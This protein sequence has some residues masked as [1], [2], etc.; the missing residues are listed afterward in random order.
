MKTPEEVEAQLTLEIEAALKAGWKLRNGSFGSSALKNC[1]ALTAKFAV[2]DPLDQHAMNTMP[3]TNRL[4]EF[5]I[6]DSA[7]LWSLVDGFDDHWNRLAE[8]RAWFAVGV[9][10]RKKFEAV[11]SR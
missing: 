1:C 8:D 5:G 10:L 2:L 6:E 4:E 11:L 9:R 3:L 7:C